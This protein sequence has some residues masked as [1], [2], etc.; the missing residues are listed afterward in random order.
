MSEVNDKLAREAALDVTQSV[1]VQAPAGS[2]KTS[3]LVSRYICLLAE[4][5]HPEEVLAITFTRKATAEMRERVLIALNPN[6]ELPFHQESVNQ[7]LLKVRQRSVELGWNLSEQPARL[8][9]M[10]IDALATS[11]IR[12]M[13][14]ASRFGSVPG[15]TEDQAP[16]YE[17]AA[18]STLES[19][20]SESTSSEFR[21]AVKR[22]HQQLD[23]KSER[24]RGLIV[25]LLQKRDQW[26][27]ILVQMPFTDSAKQEMEVTWR[28]IIELELNKTRDLIPRQWVEILG[29]TEKD[30]TDIE[31]LSVWLNLADGVLTKSGTWRKSVSD[32]QLGLKKEQVRELIADLSGISGLENRI[33]EI[34]DFPN[35]IYEQKQWEVLQAIGVVLLRAVAQLRL[36][37]RKRGRV[38]FIEIAQQAVSALGDEDKPTDLAL[39]VD[40]SYQHILVDEFQDT[41]VSQYEL[42]KALTFG[43]RP[44]DGRTLFLVGDPMQS[45]YRFREADVGIFIAVA[46][47]GIGSVK[48]KPLQL[49][50]NFRSNRALVQWFNNIFSLSFSQKSDVTSGGV[51]YA[52]ASATRDT[53]LSKPVKFWLQYN[54]T[55]IG[56]KISRSVLDAV[57]AEQL[58]DDLEDFLA[59]NP[60]SDIKIGVLVQG[61]HHAD[62]VISLLRQR[63]IKFH[64]EKFTPLNQRPVIHDL[65]SLTRALVNFADRISWMAILRAPWCGLTLDDMLIIAKNKHSIIWDVL[66][67]ESV[68]ENL[69][70]DGKLRVLRVR[71]VL[72]EVF[73]ARGQSEVRS[74]IEDCWTMLG[75]PAC[76]VKSDL[77]NAQLFLDLIDEHAEGMNIQNLDRFDEYLNALYATPEANMADAQ[78]HISTI[79]GA[80]GLEYDAVFIP[81]FDR[82]IGKPTNPLMIWSEF[83]LDTGGTALLL[84]PINPVE[85]KDGD[86]MYKF[87]KTW[88]DNKNRLEKTRLAYVAC[89]RAKSE[90]YIYAATRYKETQFLDTDE[91]RLEAPDGR[92]MMGRIWDG[93]IAHQLDDL[94]FYQPP[95]QAVAESVI[96]SPAIDLE[97]SRLPADWLCPGPPAPV[98]LLAPEYESPGDLT[99]IDF[100]WAG[101][102]ALWTGGVIHKWLEYFAHTGINAWNADRLSN[103]RPKWRESLL[104]LG[105]SR[106]E[107]EIEQALDRIELALFNVLNDPTGRWLF[108]DSHS[109]ASAE[110]QLTGY[111]NGRFENIVIDRSFVDKNGV[112]WIVDYKSGLTE[113]EVTNF[114]NQEVSRYRDQMKKYRDIFAGLDSCPI[115]LG[116]YFP[117]FPQWREVVVN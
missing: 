112:R 39:I 26:L 48:P 111:L 101:R 7:A 116:L 47:K 46:E 35:P 22:L 13:P 43:W 51:Q 79:H 66:N 102:I 99:K 27:R 95:Q 38:D 16:V 34:R 89:T 100:D 11:L 114:L 75:G 20:G 69:S 83:L 29:L 61:R 5:N 17:A 53:S 28:T 81:S 2:G 105:M 108:D 109:D 25:E 80:K 41:S 42:L 44:N 8:Q 85:H 67:D 72:H 57:Q 90:L 45:I 58:A 63:S 31:N 86:P 117:M 33:H 1:I 103:E 24:L 14:W 106:N 84:S 91:C 55:E 92:S 37:F 56:K 88:N 71:N 65:L 62:S 32:G 15:I 70:Q 104:A 77:A 74:W 36:E 68:I 110:L 18:V 54:K 73:K 98:E 49:T 4:V 113:G 52:K 19:A 23:N 87:L 115:R 10:T 21:Q 82:Y 76:V 93:F 96:P 50:E 64:D 3:L 78:V 9:I 6:T 12:R 97:I 60:S 94:R 30:S 107:F 59:R 40:Y